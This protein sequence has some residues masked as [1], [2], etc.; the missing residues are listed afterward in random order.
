MNTALNL[1]KGDNS[2]LAVSLVSP[3]E[4]TRVRFMRPPRVG[5]GRQT[6]ATFLRYS[7]QQGL[8]QR[9]LAPEDL[10]VA[11]TFDSFKI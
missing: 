10:F 7:H 6:L 4:G 8:A 5:G 1:V 9:L 3:T 2:V 11:E